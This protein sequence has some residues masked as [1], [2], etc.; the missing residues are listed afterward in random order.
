MIYHRVQ[1]RSQTTHYADEQA[2][3]VNSDLHQSDITPERKQNIISTESGIISETD[4]SS[5]GE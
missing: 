4:C 2:D 1:N 3:T 5:S